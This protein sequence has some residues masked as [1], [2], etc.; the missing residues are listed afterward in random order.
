MVI[1]IGRERSAFSFIENILAT[2]YGTIGIV[3]NWHWQWSLVTYTRALQYYFAQ[4]KSLTVS[5]YLHIVPRVTS[6][7]ASPTHKTSKIKAIT[8]HKDEEAESPVNIQQISHRAGSVA[9]LGK[10]IT[11]TPALSGFFKV[12]WTVWLA[13]PVPPWWSTVSRIHSQS[14]YASASPVDFSLSQNVTSG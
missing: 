2:M 7:A 14:T 13:V 12:I 5:Q 11:P 1:L 4:M 8:R 6:P 9:K 10:S 3:T